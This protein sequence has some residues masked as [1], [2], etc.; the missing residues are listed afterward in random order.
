M[1][2]CMK[3]SRR[4]LLKFFGSASA[5]AAIPG[6]A[7]PAR[8]SS[9]PIRGPNALNTSSTADGYLSIIQGP[10]S[11][12]ESLINVVAPRLKN[13]TYTVTDAL[14]ESVTIERYDTVSGPVFYKVDKLKVSGLRVGVEYTLKVLDKTTLIDQRTFQA[15]DV[16]K[17]DPN[18]A[19]VSCM[20][21][22]H[23]F[24][25]VIDPMWARLQ[26]QSVDFLLLCGDE[27]YVDSFEFVERQK[28]TEYDLWQRYV[29][30]LKR[31]P[32]Y[33]WRKLTPIFAV[34]DDHDYGTNDGDR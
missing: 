29:D 3:V 2:D 25:H 14:G 28:A 19:L 8:A 31:L 7:T 27:V 22:D 17:S 34:W 10:T 30:A 24:E 1:E 32:L 16:S 11:S 15:L 33:H 13:Y 20:C 21:D 12:T 26:D 18:F 4:G 5:L 6:C 9:D 23:S